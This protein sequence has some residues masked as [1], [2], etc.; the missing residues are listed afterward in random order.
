MTAL[1]KAYSGGEWVESSIESIYNY[2]DKIVFVYSFQSWSKNSQNK[3]DVIE[4]V[5]QWKNKNDKKNKIIQFSGYFESQNIQYA[6]GLNYLKKQY[7]NHH[8]LIIDCDEVWDKENLIKLSDY[9]LATKFLSYR[10][11]LFNY[12]KTPFMRIEPPEPLRPTVLLSTPKIRVSGIRFNNISKK[13]TCYIDDIFYHHFSLIRETDDLIKQKIENSLLEDNA[14]NP[15]MAALMWMEKYWNALSTANN[16]H[17]DVRHQKNWQ[18]VK[19][20]SIK[21]LP[22]AVYNNKYVRRYYDF[23]SNTQICDRTISGLQHQM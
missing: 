12:I 2:V 21:E 17:Y 4:I 14:P 13:E 19:T 9:A 15:K 10:V 7:P 3:N 23:N 20:V 1:Y 5:K 18:G 11:R 8:V 16:F 6:I 22:E